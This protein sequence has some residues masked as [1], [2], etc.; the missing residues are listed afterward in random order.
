MR[1]TQE[2]IEEI[3]SD[4][5]SIRDFTNQEREILAKQLEALVLQAKIE[6][7]GEVK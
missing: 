6:Q 3:I 5:G 1:A 2:R 7:L 4:I